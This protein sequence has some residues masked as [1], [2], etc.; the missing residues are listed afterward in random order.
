[1]WHIFLRQ[2]FSQKALVEKILNY[3]AKDTN[4]PKESR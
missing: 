4:L 3:Q 1:M 2:L